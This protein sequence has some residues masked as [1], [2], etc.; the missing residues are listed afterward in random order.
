MQK[1]VI[2]TNIIISAALSPSGKPAKIINMI[3]DSD[4]MLI[5]YSNGI[6]S[7]ASRLL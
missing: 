1:I 2:D 3:A 4:E 5:Y 6:L 7:K